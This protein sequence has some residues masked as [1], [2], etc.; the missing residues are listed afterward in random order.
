MNSS[1]WIIGLQWFFLLYFVCA[2]SAYILLNLFSIRRLKT[3]LEATSLD[4]QLDV[5]SGFEPPIS[6]LVPAFNEQTTIA[7]PTRSLLELKYSEFEVI[8]INDGSQDDTLATLTREFSLVMFPDVYWQRIKGKGVRAIYHSTVYPGLRVIDKEH[9]GKADALNTGINASRYPLYCAVDADTVVARDGL[10][11]AVQPFLEN[12][13]AV[14]SCGTV[15][16]ANGFDIKDGLVHGVEL[17]QSWFVRKQIIET[18]RVFLF[19]RMA[20]APLNAVLTVSGAFGLFRKETVIEAGGYRSGIAGTEMELVVRLH[21]LLRLAKVPYSIAYVPDAICWRNAPEKARLLKHQ[22]IRWQQGLAE[23]LALNLQLLF[24]PR[25]GAVSWLTFPFLMIFEWLGP[26]FEVT[27]YVFMIAAYVPGLIS[28]QAFVVFL[29]VAVGFGML[30]SVS[31]LLLEELTFRTY[32]RIGQLAALLIAAVLENLGYRQRVA[33]WR[34]RGLMRR[35]A[36]NG[37]KF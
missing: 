20:W 21:R 13:Y 24:N 1:N 37:I 35:L 33:W 5:Y 22:R 18:L 15:R 27:G 12:P 16:I 2:N 11:R 31:T 34:F 32:P 36:Q 29:L 30:Q 7:A 26:A 14:A 17:P 19:G 25:G 9:G 10:L 23:S 8:V 6:I 4:R 28:W 3:H